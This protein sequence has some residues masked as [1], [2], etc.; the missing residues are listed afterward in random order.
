MPICNTLQIKIIIILTIDTLT[1]MEKGEG[2]NPGVG[3]EGFGFPKYYPF[4]WLVLTI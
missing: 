3:N 1:V 2:G 4:A